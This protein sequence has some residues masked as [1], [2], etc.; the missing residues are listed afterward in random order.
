MQRDVSSGGWRSFIV[1][2]DPG[3]QRSE[4]ALDGVAERATTSRRQAVDG[5]GGAA[6]LRVNRS[7]HA[8]AVTRPSVDMA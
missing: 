5:I 7:N 3:R 4:W 8:S 1:R 2:V 6:R